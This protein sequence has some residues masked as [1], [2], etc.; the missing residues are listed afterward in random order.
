MALL[1][2]LASGSNSNVTGSGSVAFGLLASGTGDVLPPPITGTASV[3]FGLTVSAT[4]TVTPPPLGAR[5]ITRPIR[6]ATDPRQAR[7]RPSPLL[8]AARASVPPIDATGTALF[9]LTTDG[10]GTVLPPEIT[11]TAAVAFALTTAGTGDVMPPPITG[12]GAALFGIS[13]AGTATVVDTTPP[14]ARGLLRPIRT[15][16]DP[17]RAR[18]TALAQQL[19]ARVTP[20]PIDGTGLS[21]FGLTVDGAGTVTPPPISGSGT[22]DLAL[23]TTGAGT[24][25]PPP[26]SGTGSSLFGF[27]VTGSGTFGDTTPPVARGVVRPMRS[28]RDPRRMPTAGP[29][30][31]AR[32][33]IVA[34]ADGTGSAAFALTVNGAGSATPPAISGTGEAAFALTISGTGGTGD[35]TALVGRGVIRPIRQRPDPRRAPTRGPQLLAQTLHDT[36]ASG[37]TRFALAISGSGLVALPNPTQPVRV[38]DRSRRLVQVVDACTVRLAVSAPTTT[39][40][41]TAA[42]QSTRRVTVADASAPR[43][44]VRDDSYL[45]EG[46]P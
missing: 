19:A 17:R 38:V 23:T 36:P 42:D 13:V 18:R 28:R 39:P 3:A 14:V 26:I 12:T 8:V 1:L 30:V 9:A 24:V 29:Q 27:T 11:A 20:P 45:P 5:G 44:T 7:R 10:T 22:V 37:T 43:L 40:R 41:V 34:T 6:G 32:T 33:Q 46:T 21:V 4:G 25:T 35:L 16:A 15:P 31:V 2:L